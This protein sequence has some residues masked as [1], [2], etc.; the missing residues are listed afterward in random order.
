MCRLTNEFALQVRQ[1]YVA[2]ACATTLAP[3]DA[4]SHAGIA[5]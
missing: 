3:A 4:L 2:S 1:E 5:A